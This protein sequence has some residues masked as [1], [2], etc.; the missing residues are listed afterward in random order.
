VN[1]NETVSSRGLEV[2][3]G[4]STFDVF[5][6]G[7]EWTAQLRFWR[8]EHGFI[9]ASSVARLFDG[10]GMFDIHRPRGNEQSAGRRYSFRRSIY[11]K[12]KTFN[13]PF[14]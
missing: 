2:F 5:F 3:E 7:L 9:R 11:S 1:G 8:A 4:T 10:N 13:E 12:E 6:A 14:C